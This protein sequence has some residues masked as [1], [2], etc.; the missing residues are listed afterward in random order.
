M[1]YLDDN[2]ALN[3]V[4]CKLLLFIFK[5]NVNYCLLM[6]L[7]PKLHLNPKNLLK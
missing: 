1:P 6:H 2:K 3:K 7:C 4:F 5:H